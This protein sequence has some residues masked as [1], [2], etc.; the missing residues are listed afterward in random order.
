[1]AVTDLLTLDEARSAVRLPS[2]VDAHDSDL[3]DQY[4]PAV[5]TIVEDIT[6]PV[7]ARTVTHTAAGGS[8]AVL[9]GH[10]PVSVT[11][12][13]VDG[14][15]LVEGSGFVADLAAG[16]VY[17]GS[18]SSRATFAGGV[19]SVV[20]TYVAGGAADTASVP[21]AVKLG[22]GI[23]LAHLWQASRQGFRPDFGTPDDSTET[24]PSGFAVPRRA[25]ALLEP[26]A[27]TAAGFA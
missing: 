27:P 16:I 13:A 8:G 21:A 5:T 7:V 24:T 1:M 17:A 3:I 23:I 6:G 25:Y 9:L 2:G 15:A 12:V 11:S 14:G 4:V 22:A 26:Y 19:G 10:P 20:V 18:S